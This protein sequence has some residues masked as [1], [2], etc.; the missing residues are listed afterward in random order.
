MKRILI[1]F[2]LIIIFN[3]IYANEFDKKTEMLQ[4]EKLVKME[5]KIAYI[6]NEI[7]Y[8]KFENEK[9][10]RGIMLFKGQFIEEK[11]QSPG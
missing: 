8:E 1:F 3:V 4:K 2:S 7:I 6:K 11:K 5:G 10:L 9:E